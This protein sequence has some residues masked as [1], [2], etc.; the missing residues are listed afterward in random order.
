MIPHKVYSQRDKRWARI[1]LGSSVLTCGSSGC[2][3]TSIANAIG[4][5]PAELIGKLEFTDDN[6][7]YGGGLILWN[8]KNKATLRNLGLEFIGR[9]NG[10]GVDDFQ[11]MKEWCADD[12][13]VPIME[14]KT[15][16]N[17]R[18]DRHWVLPLGRRWSIWGLGWLSVDPWIGGM[19]KKT[20]GAGA[21]YMWETG[22][23]LFKRI[24]K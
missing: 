12:E 20:V 21:P 15:R 11:K 6:H 17:T 8:E 23:L 7:K 22:S 18:F 10:W 19:Q 14:V 16:T 3:A 9:Y 1:R 24:T 13:L 5:T 4:I 2:L